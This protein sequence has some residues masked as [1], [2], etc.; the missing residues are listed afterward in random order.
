MGRYLF[1]EVISCY[2]YNSACIE[3]EG[4]VIALE[5]SKNAAGNKCD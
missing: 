2:H 4:R 3:L 1:S 5:Q